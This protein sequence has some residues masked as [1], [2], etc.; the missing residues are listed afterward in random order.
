LDLTGYNVDREEAAP[1]DP[2]LV[3]LFWKLESAVD[4][5]CV[6]YLQLLDAHGE[7]VMACD[8]PP[9]REDFPVST[10]QAGDV[11]RGQHLLWLPPG[12]ES[13][14]YDW[15]LRLCPETSS[16]VCI[17]ADGV[18]HA[19]TFSLKPLDIHAPERHWT[20][21]ALDIETD[22][23]VGDVAIL[24]GVILEP[25]P[26]VRPGDV[27]H[28]TLVWRADS[29]TR[30]SYRVF[31]HLIGPE[32]TDGWP[33]SAIAQSDGVP[34]AWTRPTTGWISG[35]ILKDPRALPIPPETLPGTYRL[36]AG[37]YTLEGGRL[38]TSE[39]DD[40]VILGEIIVV[41]KPAP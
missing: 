25:G 10:W 20:V 41:D 17:S 5:S 6:A 24:L 22:V 11:W 40:A 19:P 9:V 30:T 2:L 34:G 33:L 26:S 32:N 15:R 35:E 21:P 1:G 38:P 8:L 29:E 18:M 27:L 28:T 37:M 39:G 31:L 3:T 7:Q 16:E 13:G 14:R 12:L 23:H 36:Q 4:E